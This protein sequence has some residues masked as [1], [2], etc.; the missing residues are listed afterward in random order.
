MISDFGL[1][2]KLNLGKASFSRRSGI[3]GTEGWIAPE[4]LKGQ[5]TVSIDWWAPKLNHF[6]ILQAET[7]KYAN[8]ILSIWFQTTSVDIFSLGCV[9]YCVISRGGHPFG[10]ALK[11]HA[12]ILSYEFDLK[13]FADT[14]N[15]NSSQVNSSCRTWSRHVHSIWLCFLLAVAGPRAHNRHDLQRSQQATK[16]QGNIEASLFLECWENFKL[17]T[18]NILRFWF[19]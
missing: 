11:R 16:C 15:L 12:N 4:M 3:T 2:K 13:Y 9:F 17:F 10:D 18:G 1:C 7:S 8:K 5:R 6:E 14:D 19:S